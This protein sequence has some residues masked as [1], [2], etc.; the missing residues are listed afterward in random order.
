[1]K[2]GTGF[3][4]SLYSAGGQIMNDDYNRNEDARAR[5]YIAD[6]SWLHIPQYTPNETI[7]D[8]MNAEAHL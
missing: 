4:R 2:P 5:R 1:M 8:F 6:R 7:V 3:G